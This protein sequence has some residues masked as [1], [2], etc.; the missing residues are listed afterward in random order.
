M[1][2]RTWTG[3]RKV[4]EVTMT[5]ASVG[6]IAVLI[7]YALDLFHSFEEPSWSLIIFAAALPLAASA[8]LALGYNGPQSMRIA[9]IVLAVFA[10]PTLFLGIEIRAYNFIAPS[11]DLGG[12]GQWSGL[13]IACGVAVVGWILFW[14][15]FDI[16]FT[17]PHQL[18]K[19]KLGEAYLVQPNPDDTDA[20]LSNNVSLKLSD[21]TSNRAPYHL[22]NCALNVPASE[23]PQMQ[24]RLTD[25]FPE[26]TREV[27]GIR[28]AKSEGDLFHGHIPENEVPFGF[29]DD[30]CVNHLGGAL[31]CCGGAGRTQLHQRHRHR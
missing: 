26:E 19:R 5:L 15:F 31:P 22:V 1:W 6:L 20:L 8:M 7:W 16:N 29:G 3:L 18:Y 28:E 13:A 27:R 4:A 11:Y 10:A 12:Y 9:L 25:F 17:A 14:F 2:A 30:A 24:G 23:N 21:C